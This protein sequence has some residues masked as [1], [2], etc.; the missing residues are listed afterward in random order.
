MFCDVINI[1]NYANFYIFSS[2]TL[3]WLAGEVL[4]IVDDGLHSLKSEWIKK[5]IGA[6]ARKDDMIQ[7]RQ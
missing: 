7:W 5:K 4:Q 2:C 6:L 3:F 1:V